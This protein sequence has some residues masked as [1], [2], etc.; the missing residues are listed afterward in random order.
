MNEATLLTDL[1]AV[2]ARIAADPN[3]DLVH[4]YPGYQRVKITHILVLSRS[5]Q[6]VDIVKSITSGP[7]N[8]IPSVYAPRIDVGLKVRSQLLYGNPEYIFGKPIK[9]PAAGY[10]IT[11]IDKL[12]EFRRTVMAIDEII[13][14]EH[15]ELT[16]PML[17]AIK[18]L[19]D[20]KGFAAGQRS[21][22]PPLIDDFVSNTGANYPLFAEYF[23]EM[24][25]KFITSEK[26]W[27]LNGVP[28]RISFA[29]DPKDSPNARTANAIEPAF[30]DPLLMPFLNPRDISHRVD[31]IAE[32]EA[33]VAKR[34]GSFAR[35]PRV[36]AAAAS[37]E[38]RVTGLSYTGSP[39]NN[40]AA[41]GPIG[42]NSD[43]AKLV[44]FNE[45]VFHSF[46]ST[47]DRPSFI[48]SPEAADGYGRFLNAVIADSMEKRK[49]RSK[50]SEAD[51]ESHFSSYHRKI[52]DLDLICWD[53][54]AQPVDD[55]YAVYAQEDESFQKR[56]SA[57]NIHTMRPHTR[58]P[59]DV[60][61]LIIRSC[62]GRA[63]IEHY[64]KEGIQDYLERNLR[65]DE[66]LHVEP[67]SDRVH[68]PSIKQIIRAL[69]CAR[70]GSTSDKPKW[71]T[72]DQRLARDLEM[73]A[74]QDRDVPLAIERA[75]VLALTLPESL[76]R[77]RFDKDY[78]LY[79]HWLV[80]AAKLCLSRNYNDAET[81]KM[82]KGYDHTVGPIAY[83]YGFL[84]GLLCQLQKAASGGS[85][86][87][88][89]S[90]A[91]SVMVHPG[92]TLPWYQNK[93]TFY[94]S[95]LAPLAEKNRS[96]R[97]KDGASKPSY[98]PPRFVFD[99][100]FEDVQAA[101]VSRLNGRAPQPLNPK[102][103][104][105]FVSGVAAANYDLSYRAAEERR[106]A[107]TAKTTQAA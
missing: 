101:I 37:H 88:L 95:K 76:R 100:K 49:R 21:V 32:D 60:S 36:P 40:H 43:Y 64:T 34:G 93:A 33:Q 3:N 79:M 13:A 77:K 72:L 19:Y 55:E 11:P 63:F 92:V 73:A 23:N 41:I 22:V 70:D 71:T 58:I 51:R 94:L 14:Q 30:L 98:V 16:V 85:D 18:T 9:K 12:D 45:A 17:E 83:H 5:G 6:I 2:Q 28:V 80:C 20:I 65:W 57:L 27:S 66:Q 31:E 87:S 59:S 107:N 56:C 105:Y 35:T 48:V 96:E 89:S 67:A 78:D 38:C 99:E 106:Q 82:T 74:I 54:D 103:H 15:P 53:S 26:P 97:A 7:D 69:V 50:A 104:V 75:V 86:T 42:G 90:I 39:D 44:S 4:P 84:Y 24:E 68:P 102:D 81:S 61:T 29:L 46:G 8:E 91:N 10:K 1:M 25:Q 62:R 47:T 52:G